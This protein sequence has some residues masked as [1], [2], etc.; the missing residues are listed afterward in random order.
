MKRLGNMQINSTPIVELWRLWLSYSRN[1]SENCYQNNLR[2]MGKAK[3][4][5]HEPVGDG[6]RQLPFAHPCI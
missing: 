2:R 6:H 4:A 3:R 5:H 1:R